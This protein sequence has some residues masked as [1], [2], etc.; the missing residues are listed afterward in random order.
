MIPGAAP[1]LAN[2]NPELLERIDSGEITKIVIK[3]G[4]ET[5]ESDPLSY[6]ADYIFDTDRTAKVLARR[7][8]FK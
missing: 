6:F 1:F 8:G 2:I 5:Y 3:I 4:T 7:G